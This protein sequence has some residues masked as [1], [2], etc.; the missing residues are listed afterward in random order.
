MTKTR[1]KPGRKKMPSNQRP[2]HGVFVR[3]SDPE[4]AFLRRYA[5]ADGQSTAYTAK[6]FLLSCMR[7]EGYEE[8]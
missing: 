7:S 2:K 4:W 8:S 6:R 5:K 3:L 1:K